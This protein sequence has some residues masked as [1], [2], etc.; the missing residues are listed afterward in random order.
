MHSRFPGIMV[1]IAADAGSAAISAPTSGSAQTP[2]SSAA[3]PAGLKTPWGEPDL[4]GIWTDETT[5][6][7]QRPAKYANQELFTEEQRAELDRIRAT[8]PGRDTRAPRGS[9]QDV[10]G[11]YNN[12]WGGL[13]RTGKRTSMIIDPPDGHIPPV[14]PEAEKIARQDRDFRLALMRAT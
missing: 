11:A 14:K 4:Q 1:A 7:L 10:A 2:E 12:V 6:P 5:T 13:K 3:P 9:E 8:F